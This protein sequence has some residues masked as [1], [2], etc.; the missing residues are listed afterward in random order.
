ME[1]ALGRRLDRGCN[2]SRVSVR[3]LEIS[4]E[5]INIR[6]TI[7]RAL[8]STSN[9]LSAQVHI[10][11]SR[12]HVA[13]ILVRNVSPNRSDGVRQGKREGKRA[14][15]HACSVVHNTSI[16]SLIERL[17]EHRNSSS[18]MVYFGTSVSWLVKGRNQGR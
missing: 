14:R 15:M 8:R 1:V 9:N 6:I 7:V 11:K 13:G 18:L 16:A 4:T 10:S 2:E 17:N 5:S 12:S 3:A